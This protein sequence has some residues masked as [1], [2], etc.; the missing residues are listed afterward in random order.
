MAAAVVVMRMRLVHAADFRTRRIPFRPGPDDAVPAA[1]CAYY[2]K[3]RMGK[4]KKKWVED[5]RDH[6][7]DD[8]EGDADRR[9]TAFLLQAIGLWRTTA[10][11]TGK[12]MRQERKPVP[13]ETSDCHHENDGHQQENVNAGVMRL[14]H[15]ENSVSGICP[16]D[17]CPCPGS[18]C[19]EIRS[20]RHQL[21][22]DPGTPGTVGL[23]GM[24]LL[25]HGQQKQSRNQIEQQAGSKNRSSE[26]IANSA[27]D[28]GN[29]VWMEKPAGSR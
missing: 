27:A 23:S 21:P 8:G 20:T 22:D 18:H 19:E 7:A 6:D 10:E 9:L 5:R 1:G 4:E 24:Q 2:L 13:G 29:A 25:S 28:A 3:K 12:Q 15:E 14:H 17:C 16:V 11:T 26:C